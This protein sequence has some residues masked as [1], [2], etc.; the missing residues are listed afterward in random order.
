MRRVHRH[1]T[2]AHRWGL[3]SIVRSGRCGLVLSMFVGACGA[4]SGAPS[5]GTTDEGTLWRVSP[6]EAY[7]ELCLV[8]VLT[9]DP[10]YLQWYQ[11]AYDAYA[12]RIPDEVRR[13]LSVLKTRIKDQDGGIVSAFLTLVLSAGDPN[14]LADL[15]RLTEHPTELRTRFAATQFWSE[16]SWQRFDDLRGDLLVA[17]RFLRDDGYPRRWQAQVRPRVERRADTV[18]A[19]LANYD[20]VGLVQRMVPAPRDS[21]VGVILTTMCQPHGIRITGDRY[22]TDVTYPDAIVLRNAVHEMLHPPYDLATDTALAAALDTWRESPW[23]MARVEGHDPSFG[24]NSF[25]GLVEED[26][27]QATEQ[28]IL[29]SLGAAVPPADRWQNADEG[30]HG[31]AAAIYRVMRERGF[32]A[33]Y[34]GVADFLRR[35][36]GTGRLAPGRLD[37]LAAETLEGDPTPDR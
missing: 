31:L 30:L 23:L 29:D 15:I 16:D 14:D 7:D 28:V 34:A 36:I 37:S 32:P 35:E 13:S 27:V 3:P 4:A 12:P 25:A 20:I 1:P 18:A 2:R 21:A 33:G 10:F 26:V 5:V 19:R 8:N 17:L 24:Y 22:L 11:A 9:G 6:S